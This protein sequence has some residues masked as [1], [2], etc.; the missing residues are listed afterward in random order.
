MG[1]AALRYESQQNFQTDKLRIQNQGKILFHL[2]SKPWEGG[3]GQ[4]I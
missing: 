1:V 3:W 4:Y 2:R